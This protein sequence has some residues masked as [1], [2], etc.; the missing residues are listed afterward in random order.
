MAPAIAPSATANA[1]E[2]IGRAASPQANTPATVASLKTS[3]S[4]NG[5]SGPSAIAQPIWAASGLA[6]AVRLTV[7]K[8]ARATRGDLI[9]IIGGLMK[10]KDKFDAILVETT[11]LA[12]PG[13]VVQTFFVDDEVRARTK[14]DAVVTV[15]DA[16]HLLQRL[17]D[18]H[19]AEEQIAF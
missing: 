17:E 18:S 5:P 10:R 14:L 7:N 1:T 4:I 8:P 3:V 15:A 12:D 16:K 19:E 13:P 6:G 2:P 9:R 11:G